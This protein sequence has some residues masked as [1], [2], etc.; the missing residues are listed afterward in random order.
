M[1][2][3]TIIF[4]G[5]VFVHAWHLVNAWSAVQNTH[6]I[7]FHVVVVVLLVESHICRGLFRGVYL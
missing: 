6:V 2:V 5:L 7:R 1:C 3:N 4:T